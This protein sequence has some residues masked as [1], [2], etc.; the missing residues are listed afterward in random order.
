MSDILSKANFDPFLNQTFTMKGEGVDGISL[1]LSKITE[2]S[3][4]DS[5]RFSLEFK[6]P[7]DRMFPQMVYTIT[8]EEM[9]DL[10]LFLVPVAPGCYEAL[11]NRLKE[12]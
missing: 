9:G 1:E 10:N 11:F 2:S 12:E 4:K 8:H 6:G 3:N 7:E 5:I